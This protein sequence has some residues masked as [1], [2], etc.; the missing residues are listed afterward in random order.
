MQPVESIINNYR[1]DTPYNVLTFNT[2]NNR[3][4]ENL[5]SEDV[6]MYLWEDANFSNTEIDK[7]PKISNNNLSISKIDAIIVTDITTQLQIAYKLSTF[8]HCN[9][10]L[11]ITTPGPR[12][13]ILAHI[14]QN[15]EIPNA[16]FINVITSSKELAKT[17]HTNFTIERASGQFNIEFPEAINQRLVL[18]NGYIDKTGLDIIKNNI[19]DIMLLSIDN[20]RSDMGRPLCF[21]NMFNDLNEETIFMMNHLP[22]ISLDLSHSLKLTNFVDYLMLQNN[23]VQS[24]VNNIR[25]LTESPTLQKIKTDKYTCISLSSFKYKWNNLIKFTARSPYRR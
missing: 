17:I 1:G 5:E 4:L 6:Q 19:K 9:I 3:L 18:H 11:Y 12:L 22:V 16:P 14:D 24:I 8:F 21:L 10:I 7:Y 15:L 2:Y 13:P 25:I 23:D 20:Y